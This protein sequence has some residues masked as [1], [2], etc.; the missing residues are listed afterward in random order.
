M[1]RTLT[2]DLPQRI[3]Q[4]VTVRGWVHRRRRLSRVAFLVVRDRSGLA[5]VVADGRLLDAIGEETVVA[6]EG[7]VVA[8]PKAP[9][10]AELTDPRITVLGSATM[11]G[12]FERVYEVGPVFRAEPHDTV[13]HLHRLAP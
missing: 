6:V 12:V 5:Q 4:R 10:G 2:A 1:S 9:G 8:N 7:I 13:R 11:V 3:G